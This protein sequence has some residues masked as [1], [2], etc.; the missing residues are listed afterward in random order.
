[1]PNGGVPRQMAL[2]TRDGCA[3]LHVNGD[4]VAIHTRDGWE[5]DRSQAVPLAVLSRAEASALAS[6]LA[7]WLFDIHL[8]PGPL[9]RTGAH[10]QFD[11]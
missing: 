7:Y 1:M 9:G 6:F 8:G 2:R 10:V 5:R 4:E 3:V 11:W